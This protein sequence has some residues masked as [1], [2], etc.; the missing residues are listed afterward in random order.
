MNCC[1]SMPVCALMHLLGAIYPS[2][3]RAQLSPSI[4]SSMERWQA[5]PAHADAIWKCAEHAPAL[6]H[7][8]AHPDVHA[9]IRNARGSLYVPACTP[10]WA[11]LQSVSSRCVCS[12]LCELQVQLC[13]SFRCN[14]SGW[15]HADLRHNILVGSAALSLFAVC[16][17]RT[18]CSCGT[19]YTK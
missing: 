15:T 2:L 5:I 6:C 4:P 16:R 14:Q 3:V 17:C 9:N 12:A 18:C 10:S 7:L 1:R 13:A 19:S 8:L 11:R